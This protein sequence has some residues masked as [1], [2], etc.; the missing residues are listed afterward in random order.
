[1]T[2]NRVNDL[3]VDYAEDTLSVRKRA[4]VDD[5]LSTCE[6]CRSDLSQIEALKA[7]ILSVETP[8][9]DAVFWE[10]FNRKLSQK[11]A[12]I[13]EP[14]AGRRFIL[15]PQFSL[16]AAMVI[17]VLLSIGI[18]RGVR[19]SGDEVPEPDPETAWLAAIEPDDLETGLFISD[20]YDETDVYL[21]DS[22]YQIVEQ[23]ADEILMMANGDVDALFEESMFEDSYDEILDEMLENLSEEEFEEL[24][25]RMAS[26]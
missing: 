19:E 8:K 25:R 13:E 12:E 24:Y 20:N 11:L 6:V 16:A 2:C 15:R 1:M 3:L 10:R 22:D 17:L 21:S 14:A 4:A 26:T 18:L 9:C 7:D 23:L 5:H